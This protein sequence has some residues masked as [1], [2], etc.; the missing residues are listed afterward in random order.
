MTVIEIVVLLR[1]GISYLSIVTPDLA[2]SAY[3]FIMEEGAKAGL[4]ILREVFIIIHFN[5]LID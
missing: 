5:I 3:I 4:Y 1:K 2:P